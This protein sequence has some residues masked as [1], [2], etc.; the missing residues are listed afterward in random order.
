MDD[1]IEYHNTDRLHFSLDMD[2]YETLLMA[3]RN[4]KAND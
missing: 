4:K 3:F 2:N 1:C